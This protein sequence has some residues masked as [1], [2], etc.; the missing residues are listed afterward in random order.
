MQLTVQ[1]RFSAGQATLDSDLRALQIVERDGQLALYGASGTGGGISSYRLSA[2]GTATFQDSHFYALDPTT[3]GPGHLGMLGEGD[4]AQLLFSSAGGV[5]TLRLSPDATLGAATQ[6]TGVSPNTPL[7]AL[8]TLALTDST[9]LFTASSTAAQVSL[10][11][12]NGAEITT[13]APRSLPA[14]TDATTLSTAVIADTALLLSTDSSQIHSHR[15]STTGYLTPLTTLGANEGFGLAQPTAMEVVG[16]FGRTWAILTAADSNSLSVIEVDATGSLTPRDHLIDTR[17]TRFAGAQALSVVTVEGRE[18]AGEHVLVITG[19]RDD[20]LSLFA[21]LPD[22]RLTHLHSIEH[23]DGRGLMDVRQITAR[24]MGDQL[25]I[26]VTS[27]AEGGIT[28]LHVPLATLGLAPSTGT[29]PSTGGLNGGAG[30]DLLLAQ[31]GSRLTGGAGAD[32]FILAPLGD[33]TITDFDPGADRLDLSAWAMLRSAAQLQITATGTGAEVRYRDNTLVLNSANGQPFEDPHALLAAQFT[34]ADR[35]LI[36]GQPQGMTLEGSVEANSLTGSNGDDVIT[37]SSG[38]D[39]VISYAGDDLIN[40]GGDDDR[41]FAGDGADTIWGAA[42]HDTLWGEAGDDVLG[43]GTGSDTIWAGDGH[44]HVYGG[45][46]WDELGGADGHDTI[47]ASD[48]ND[49]LYGGAGNDVLGGGRDDD[50]VWGDGGN[51][52]LYGGEG[53]DELGGGAGNDTLWASAGDDLLWGG[54]GDDQL[55]GGPGDDTLWGGAGSDTFVFGATSEGVADPMNGSD[56]IGDFT[57]G[58]D[59]L[60]FTPNTG[61]GPVQFS[62]LTLSD[63]TEGLQITYD[64]GRLLLIGLEMADFSTSDVLFG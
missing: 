32:L 46:G 9:L 13:A 52:L 17:A 10:T 38:N 20:G 1:G 48:G 15:I 54:A 33:A 11:R 58:S 64:G 26:F 29:P 50:T 55:S 3:L 24:Q 2:S 25:Q 43:G 47:W 42:G 28:Q 63:T 4:Q 16:A 44:D 45:A 34:G 27:E 39:S 19:G 23:R 57:A 53:R 6:L 62:D 49:T 37:A 59:R 21:L 31:D 12:I 5:Q 61:G 14:L 35:A 18:E 40:A 56:Q 60:H 51:D 22:G 36:L 41:I 7:T 8:A 30:D